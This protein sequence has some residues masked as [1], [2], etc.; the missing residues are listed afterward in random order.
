M[1][2]GTLRLR[3]AHQQRLDLIVARR[4]IPKSEGIAVAL[5]A[6]D[7]GFAWLQTLDV[8]AEGWRTV[9]P[10]RQPWL[11][12]GFLRRDYDQASGD[13]ALLQTRGVSPQT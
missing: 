10:E 6:D 7:G 1:T 4:Q 8:D 12:G 13:R 3:V 11:G 9:E 5:R 2:I